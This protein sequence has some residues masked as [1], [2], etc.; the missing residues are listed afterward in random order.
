[1][2]N[3]Y[4]ITIIGAGPIGIF[5]GTY[6]L[7]RQA[8]V[9]IIESLPQI[10]GQVSTLFPNKQIYDIPGFPKISGT[11]LI[12]DLKE[13][14][15]LFSPEI[16]LNETV[17]NFEKE[18]NYFKIHTDHR[19]TYSK[20]IIL[21]TGIGA[22]EPRKLRL[23]NASQFEN[24][25]LF[26]SVPHIEDF[27]NKD[28]VVAGGGNSAAD[29]TIELARVAHNVTLL[30]R[31]DQ[32]RALEC[33]IKQIEHL[34]NADI[35]TP[36]II[37][38]LDLTDDNKLQIT[39]KRTRTRDDFNQ[40]VTD[41]L[42]V[43]Y[44]VVTDNSTLKHWNLKTQNGQIIVNEYQETST[45]GI[46]AVGDN[47]FA[48]E[49]INLIATGFGEAPIAVSHALE[50]IYPEKRQPAHSTQLMEDFKL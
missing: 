11:A 35:L 49:K 25:Q 28:I 44:G 41:A 29:W 4:D 1:M 26:Y 14:L 7:M 6:A 12:Q 23:K 38:G 42:I 31:R 43:N 20:A 22:F 19:T 2:K 45:P 16:H 34:S 48:A 10:G 8:K 47:A 18:K 30:H 36:F 9:Q 24:K 5:T 21:A 40:L 17:L 13:Q 46:Y 15:N 39:L 33:S 50:K 27:K 37:N 3:I 32:F